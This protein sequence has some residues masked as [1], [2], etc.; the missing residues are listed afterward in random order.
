M[1]R[2]PGA[3]GTAVPPLG[4]R[5]RATQTSSPCA[6]D[7]QGDPT[8]PLPGRVPAQGP[9]TRGQRPQEGP[10]DRKGLSHP[11]THTRQVHAHSYTCAHQHGHTSVLTLRDD[12][13]RP[14]P[15]R[16][17]VYVCAHSSTHTHTQLTVRSWSKTPRGLSK[18]LHLP[19]FRGLSCGFKQQLSRWEGGQGVGLEVS[20]PVQ[21]SVGTLCPRPAAGSGLSIPPVTPCAAASRGPSA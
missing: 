6:G 4:K 20:S 5:E 11:E 15:L 21:G 9:E 19:L 17:R 2:G 7:Q 18:R 10:G 1:G 3:R 12:A 16:A 14:T 8:L 13:H